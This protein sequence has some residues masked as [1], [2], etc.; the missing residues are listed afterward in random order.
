MMGNGLYFKKKD[1]KESN[2]INRINELRD[3]LHNALDMGDK[4]EILSISQEL[5]RMIVTYLRNDVKKLA[6]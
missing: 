1:Y 4:E 3:K 2:S 5:D 6:V